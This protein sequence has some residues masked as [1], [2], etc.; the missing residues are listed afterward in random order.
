[1]YWY[2]R[3]FLVDSAA[4]AALGAFGVGVVT[5]SCGRRQEYAAPV[6]PDQAPDGRVLRAGVADCG[7]LGTGAA[8][9]VLLHGSRE[10][11]HRYDGPCIFKCSWNRFAV[12]Q[13]TIR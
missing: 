13:K 4:I 10:N 2:R 1:M 8:M 3:N 5:S 11:G 9:S 7:G 12:F 6:F